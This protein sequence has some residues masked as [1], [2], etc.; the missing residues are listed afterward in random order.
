MSA[1]AIPQ[2]GR[3]TCTSQPGERE[4]RHEGRPVNVGDT[5]RWLSLLGGGALALL[6]LSRRSLPGLGLAAV[7]GSLLYRGA[8]G[9]CS[10][11]NALGVTTAEPHGPATR[12]PAGHGFKVEES[13]LVNR[14]AADLY[15]YWRNFENLGRFMQYLESVTTHGNRSHWVARGPLGLKVEWD[16][17]IITERENEMIGWRSLEGGGVETA[18]SVHF[19]PQPHDRGTLVRVS[20][21]YDPPGGKA[22]GVIAGLFGRAPESIIREDLRRFKRVMEAGEI[23]TTSGQPRGTCR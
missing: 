15:R 14:P 4:H 17:E 16:A 21:K 5:E 1:T 7:G 18:G 9:H 11:Y 2:A 13:V 12:I 22:G 20:L 19:Q 3:P 6:G 8:S 23:P 10:L